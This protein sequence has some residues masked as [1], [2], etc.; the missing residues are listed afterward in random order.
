MTDSETST[1][2]ASDDEVQVVKLMKQG[3]DLFKIL[4]FEGLVASGGEAKAAI[5]GGLVTLNAV[6]ET[7]KRKKIFSG[8][9]IEFG[10]VSYRMHCDEAIEP[11]TLDGIATD[12]NKKHGV[13]AGKPIRKS[14]VNTKRKMPAPK[15]AGRKAIGIKS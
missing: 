4:K 15:K 2:A 7:Q 10:G 9:I 6:I 13:G 14:T 1:T 8:D 11:V 5:A 12:E 3:I